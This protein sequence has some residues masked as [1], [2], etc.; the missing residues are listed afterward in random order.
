VLHLG[1][2]LFCIGHV[3]TVIASTATATSSTTPASIMP[4][5]TTSTAERIELRS[6]SSSIFYSA[7]PIL[8]IPR[9]NLVGTGFESYTI[10][11]LELPLQKGKSSQES[12]QFGI[13][14]KICKRGLRD[15][16]FC[17]RSID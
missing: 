14:L 2:R 13:F 11:E 7:V 16:L 8:A 10:D 12:Q 9:S 5:S 1:G 4:T 17:P 6:V 3:G 15:S